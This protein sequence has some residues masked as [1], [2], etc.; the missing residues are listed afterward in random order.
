M[1]TQGSVQSPAAKKCKHCEHTDHLRR[2]SAR[3]Q[4][5]NSKMLAA[6]RVEL[7]HEITGNTDFT[8]DESN[9]CG[10]SVAGVILQDRDTP[11]NLKQVSKFN[12]TN[13]ICSDVGI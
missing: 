11:V 8:V 13:Q 1:D 3:C 4:Y 7:V 5:N 10:S 12:S 2:T 6:P 9:T